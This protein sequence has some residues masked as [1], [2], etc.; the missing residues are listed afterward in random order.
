MLGEAS[1]RREYFTQCKVRLCN[2]KEFLRAP[3]SKTLVTPT[4]VKMGSSGGANLQNRPLSR[5]VGGKEEV[6]SRPI[7]LGK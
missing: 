4:G 7:K 5:I 6:C 3:R 1:V 2:L